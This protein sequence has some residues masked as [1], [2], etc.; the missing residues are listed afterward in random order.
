MGH[1]PYRVTASVTYKEEV[2]HV[3]EGGGGKFGQDPEGVTA[4]VD[5]KEY[6]TKLW[7]LTFYLGGMSTINQRPTVGQ[8][9]EY[10]RSPRGELSSYPSQNPN[11]SSTIPIT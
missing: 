6:I 10:S 8:V 3:P 11:L 7:Y 4:S 2:M 1:A 5:H 9:S